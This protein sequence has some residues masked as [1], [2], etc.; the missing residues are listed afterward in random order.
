M[1]QDFYSSSLEEIECIHRRRTLQRSGHSVRILQEG[2]SRSTRPCHRR[3]RLH[4][5]VGPVSATCGSQFLH[6]PANMDGIAS[7]PLDTGEFYMQLQPPGAHG[8]RESCFLFFV[9]RNRR[10]Q[11]T[12]LTH[13]AWAFRE[14]TDAESP[15]ARCERSLFGGICML[16]RQSG[17]YL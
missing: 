5:K 2:R 9:L 7:R 17:F 10:P 1:P 13:T 15:T 6:C 16:Q 3:L 8:A 14:A 11:P 4:W 12:E